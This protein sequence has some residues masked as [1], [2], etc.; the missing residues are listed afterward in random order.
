M[1]RQS[2]HVVHRRRGI[3]QALLVCFAFLAGPVASAG[4]ADAASR[5]VRLTLA[6]AST[7]WLEGTSTLH[8][9]SSHATAITATVEI[10]LPA[11]EVNP[12]RALS[13]ALREGS[14]EKFEFVVP[15]IG[16]KSETGGLDKNLYKAL[17]A[18]QAPDIRFHLTSRSVKPSPLKPGSYVM[19][20]AG[21][22]TIAGQTQ[23]ITLTAD[24]RATATGLHITGTKQLL[25]SSYGV[26][27]PKM[28]LGTIKTGDKVVVHFDV[29]FVTAP[30]VVH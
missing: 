28:M 25:M 10:A 17:K 6:P 27:P 9:Y 19:D 3:A 2:G 20:C 11:R 23:D 13:R 1:T 24:A 18:K 15:V 5:T 26:K 29:T 12:R 30:A 8:A 21:A 22:L 14:I 4:A 7:L 16:L